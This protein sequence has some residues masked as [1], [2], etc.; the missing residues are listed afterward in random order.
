MRNKADMRAQRE[1][2]WWIRQGGRDYQ[3]V[4]AMAGMDHDFLRE[5]YEAGKIDPQILRASTAAA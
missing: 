4:C 3:T 1:A 2:D 5:A